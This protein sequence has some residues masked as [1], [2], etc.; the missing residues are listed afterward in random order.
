M[1]NIWAVHHDPSIWKDPEKFCPERFLDEQ[2]NFIN[3][4]YVIP[5]SIGPRHCL[6]EQLARME[7]FIFLIGIVQKFEI[8]PNPTVDQLPNIDDGSMGMMFA[9]SKFLAVAKE[10]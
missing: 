6:G 5:F 8:L 4:N 3:S 9:P 1:G 10:L 2:G 7:V